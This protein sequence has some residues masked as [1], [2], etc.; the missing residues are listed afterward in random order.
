MLK[1]VTFITELCSS[2]NTED[3]YSTLPVNRKGEPRKQP[4]KAQEQNTGKKVDLCEGGDTRTS[5]NEYQE[6]SNNLKLHL[7]RTGDS[8]KDINENKEKKCGH[9]RNDA[10]LDDKNHEQGRQGKDNNVQFMEI[11]YKCADDMKSVLC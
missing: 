2:G 10:E 7:T 9:E 8:E 11:P 3:K 6:R 4:P 1:V 5:L